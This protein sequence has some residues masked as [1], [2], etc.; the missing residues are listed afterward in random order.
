MVENRGGDV[1]KINNQ[2]MTFIGD[3]GCSYHI[4]SCNKHLQE[5]ARESSGEETKVYLT[6]K[7]FTME[8]SLQDD[9]PIIITIVEGKEVKNVRLLKNTLYVKESE[10]NLL[11]GT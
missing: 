11:D 9:L 3:S 2:E 1:K 6:K 4:L 5:N 7:N 10:D 8:A